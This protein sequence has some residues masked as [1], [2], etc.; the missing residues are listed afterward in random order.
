MTGTDV[1]RMQLMGSCD[2]VAAQARQAADIWLTRA[3]DSAS[4]PGFALWHCARVVDWAVHAVVRDTVE[5]GETP[6]WRERIRY[7][8]GHG[9]GLTRE[10]ADDAAHTVSP[11][12][13]AGYAA[14]LRESITGWIDTI[15]D[16]DLDRPADVRSATQRNPLY[17]TAAAWEE[18]ESLHGIPVWQVLVRPSVS[19]IRMH[20]GELELL[21]A[22]LGQA[23]APR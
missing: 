18:V 19:H 2:M 11:E 1:L 13:I 14:T 22:M 8:L 21:T 7:D 3:F 6:E 16:S 4:L 20:I 5:V 23:A 12:D 17:A 9:A 10:Q 15:T